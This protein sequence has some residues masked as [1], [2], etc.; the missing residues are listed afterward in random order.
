MEF[1]HLSFILTILSVNVLMYCNILRYLQPCVEL[2]DIEKIKKLYSACLNIYCKKGLPGVCDLAE[3][4]AEICHL[5][6]GKPM[7]QLDV[8]G[9]LLLFYIL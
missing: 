3:N 9:K 6:F 4:I 8:C 7:Q 5:K 1:T 2:F